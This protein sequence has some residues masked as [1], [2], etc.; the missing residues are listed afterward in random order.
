[1]F[2]PQAEVAGKMLHDRRLADTGA[3][4]DVKHA[5]RVESRVS[6]VDQFGPGQPYAADLV[7]HF[8]QCAIRRF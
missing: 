3:A 2:G 6:L 8:I 1:M 5:L 7:L 4:D